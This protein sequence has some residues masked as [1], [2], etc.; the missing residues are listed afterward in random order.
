MSASSAVFTSDCVFLPG[1]EDPVPATI[2]IDVAKGT[3]ISVH[4]GR[5]VPENYSDIPKERWHDFGD[6]WILPGLV[7]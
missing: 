1:N 3:I 7:E 6:K 4:Q 2:V 5:G